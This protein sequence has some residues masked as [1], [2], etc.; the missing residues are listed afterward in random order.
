MSLSVQQ[1]RDLN[2]IQ[3][4]VTSCSDPAGEYSDGSSS[5]ADVWSFGMYSE[6]GLGLEAPI[7]TTSVF[8]ALPGSGLGDTIVG[9][10]LS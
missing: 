1:I 2:K 3:L 5:T 8:G 10:V 7:K 4:F 9:P 6:G